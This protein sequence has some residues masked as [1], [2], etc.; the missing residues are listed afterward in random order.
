MYLM[1]Y[2]GSC[3]CSNLYGVSI[4]TIGCR[5]HHYLINFIFEKSAYI[6]VTTILIDT[7]EKAPFVGKL[8]S[9]L[10]R[11]NI[12]WK[13]FSL[14]VG[15]ISINDG[16]TIKALIEH[17]SYA[18]FVSSLQSGHLESQMFDLDR[19]DAPT[20][21]FIDGLHS[22]WV[23]TSAA[24]YFKQGIDYINGY[25]MRSQLIHKTRIVQFDTTPQLCRAIPILCKQLSNTQ[26]LSSTTIIPERHTSSGDPT[27]DMF[28]TI[29]GIGIKTAEKLIEKRVSLGYLYAMAHRLKPDVAKE[30]LKAE[31]QISLPEKAFEYLGK[32][33]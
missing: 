13:R 19:V 23:R 21:L 3:N 6:L 27:K 24:S 5:L 14:T 30:L 22:H 16:D 32:V 17:K 15:D 26:G 2:L 33:L 20:F 4:R 10:D 31:M 7:R 28:L 11:E 8:T 29:D 12:P 1:D 18:D 9:A 25:K